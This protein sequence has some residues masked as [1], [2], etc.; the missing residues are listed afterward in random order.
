MSA[1]ERPL[2]GCCSR[3]S[4]GLDTESGRQF[5][6]YTLF[7]EVAK[8]ATTNQQDG[9]IATDTH[10]VNEADIKKN[11]TIDCRDWFCSFLDRPSHRTTSFSSHTDFSVGT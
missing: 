2:V 8:C 3:Q 10:K 4:R 11:K 9:F 7:V 6:F 1:I 5:C